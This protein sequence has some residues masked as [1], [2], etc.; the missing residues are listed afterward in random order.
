[1]KVDKT[2]VTVAAVCV[3]LFLSAVGLGFFL[4]YQ[5]TKTIKII[6]VSKNDEESDFWSALVAGAKMAAKE[7]NAEFTILA[8]RQELDVEYQNDLINQAIA[9]KPEV[10]LLTPSDY[11]ATLKKAKEIQKKGIKLVLVDSILSENIADA[12]VATDNIAS[13]KEMGTFANTLVTEQTKIGI[14]SH[15]KGSSTAIEREEGVRQG[16]LENHSKVVDIVYSDSQYSKAY[17]VTKKLLLAHPDID[18]LIG[19]NEYST[20]GAARVV[21]DMDLEEHVNIIGFDNSMEEIHLLES[22]VIDGIVSQRPFEMGY[23]GVEVAVELARGENV[24]KSID[25]GA[26]LILKEEIYTPE[27]QKILFPFWGEKGK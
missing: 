23:L 24:E 27:N 21:K 9:M 10:I 4:H 7:F 19:L 22:G 2:K 12:V 16:L 14:V 11:E 20:V 26:K 17:D 25:S 15:V 3:G 6:Y 13:G 1:M 5:Q 8:P 18:L